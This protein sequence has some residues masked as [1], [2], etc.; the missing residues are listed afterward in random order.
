MKVELIKKQKKDASVKRFIVQPSA[1]VLEVMKQIDSSARG[2]AYVCDGKKLIGTVSDGDIRRFIIKNGNLGTA[3]AEIVNK[4]FKYITENRRED[5]DLIMQKELISSVP[6]LNED[7]EILKIFFLQEESAC[8]KKQIDVPVVIMAGG[9]GS[10]L[11]PYTNILPKPLIPIGER[12]IT[13]H[14]MERFLAYGCHQFDMIV[15]Y[16]R[17]FIQS[18]FADLEKQYDIEF[19][20][21]EEFLGTGG[22]LRLLKGKYKKPFFLTNCDILVEEDYSHIYNKHKER[23]NIITMVCAVKNIKLPYGTVDMSEAGAVSKINEKPEMSFM[24]N[25]GLY[26]ISP[27]FIDHIPEGKSVP[28]TDVI[29]ECIESGEKVGVYPVSEE[30][31]YDMGQ[32]EEMERMKRHLSM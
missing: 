29:Q 26:V 23:K 18:Y 1:T 15:N 17:H 19:T 14:I 10:R 20:I 5:A 4:E 2:I 27:A 3:V 21:E 25:T 28:I 9:I 31:W 30:R 8:E 7:G 22:G 6:L 16:K 12:T 11:Q 32:F 24:T 13:E